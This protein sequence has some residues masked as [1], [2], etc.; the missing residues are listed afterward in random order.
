MGSSTGSLLVAD[1]AGVAE[2]LRQTRR[3][4]AFHS[5]DEYR[6]IE[7]M[8][9][10]VAG[11]PAS[12]PV[13]RDALTALTCTQRLI[14]IARQERARIHV[15]HVSTGEE[16]EFL[17]QHKDIASVEVTPHHLTLSADDYA[18]LGTK[19]QMNPP[20]RDKS[21]R[22]KIWRGLDQGVVDVLGSDHA[23]HTLEEKAKAYPDSP[24]GMTGVQTLVPI[25]LDHVAA[26]RLTLARFVDLTS[27][28]PARLFQLARKGRVAVGYDADLTVVDLKRRQT[29]TDNWIASRCGWTPYDGKNV[30]GWP[31]GTFVR[32]A[33][34]MWEGELA[35]AR[36]R[37][38]DPV[39]G[40]FV[41]AFPFTP[42]CEDAP[43]CISAPI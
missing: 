13:W 29:I 18:Q 22:E 15:L 6:L 20:V 2:I 40:G 11:D 33:R 10:R 28:G 31:V 35:D 37:Q 19:I 14:A 38:A 16:I 41:K 26:G 4:A 24:S 3:R 34:V 36:D 32:G 8:G 23:P 5:E 42:P 21:H 25:M 39:S 27:A 9:E 17:S 30:T 12:H 7:R 1:D 43:P